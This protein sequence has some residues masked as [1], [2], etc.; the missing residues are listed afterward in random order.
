MRQPD[1]K[2]G[3]WHHELEV[4]YDDIQVKYDLNV[5]QRKLVGRK[6]HNVHRLFS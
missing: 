6:G 4:K 3:P 1:W 5:S 2:G